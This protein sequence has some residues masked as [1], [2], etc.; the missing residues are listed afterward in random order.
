MVID[1]AITRK[2]VTIAQFS[3]LHFKCFLTVNTLQQNL[4]FKTYEHYVKAVN[5]DPI[6][7]KFRNS[8]KR[9]SIYRLTDRMSD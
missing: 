2:S 1:T 4:C 8:S 6:K 5:L 3:T 9:V 7:F